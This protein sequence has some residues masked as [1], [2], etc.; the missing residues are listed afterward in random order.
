[1]VACSKM[2]AE[3]EISSGI[4]YIDAIWYRGSFDVR[5]EEEE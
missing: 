3:K 5:C 1:M 2:V 4:W